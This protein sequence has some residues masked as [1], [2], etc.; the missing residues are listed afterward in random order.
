[1][2]NLKRSLFSTQNLGPQLLVVSVAF[3]AISLIV[4]GFRLYTQVFVAQR[5]KLHDYLMVVAVVSILYPSI[6][7]GY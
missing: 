2:E 3:P 5:I 7:L 1:M 6:P 4:V